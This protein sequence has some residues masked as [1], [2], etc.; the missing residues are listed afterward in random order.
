[1]LTIGGAPQAIVANLV[2]AL[3]QHVLE[4]A[5][6]E[7]LSKDGHR[8]GQITV[9]IFIP[10]GHLSIVDRED[11]A[12]G[13]GDPVNVAAQIVENLPGALDR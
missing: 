1:M 13:D 5:S 8:F 7:F 4:K 3:R 12:V 9:G 6:N 10:K 2:K 11:S